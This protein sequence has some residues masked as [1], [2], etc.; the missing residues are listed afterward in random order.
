LAGGVDEFDD[1]PTFNVLAVLTA[2]Q[3][4]QSPDFAEKNQVWVTGIGSGRF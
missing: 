3:M 1:F 2:L 4:Q